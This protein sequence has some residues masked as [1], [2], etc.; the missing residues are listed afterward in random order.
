[1]LREPMEPERGLMLLTMDLSGTASELD[2][3]FG[4]LLWLGN[5]LME[6]RI[7]FDICALTGNGIESWT[8]RDEWDLKKCMEALLCSPFAPEGS[9]QDRSF[10]AAWRHHIGGETD[11]A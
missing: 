7:G 4:R 11:E 1:M 10:Q 6:N 8:I 2:L 5:W 3:K 9:I